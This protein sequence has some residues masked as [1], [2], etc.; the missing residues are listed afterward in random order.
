MNQLLSS[1]K[2][3]LQETPTVQV[4]LVVRSPPLWLG[5][6]QTVLA[7]LDVLREPGS[8]PRPCLTRLT[9]LQLV[10]TKSPKLKFL[11]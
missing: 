1:K 8:A 3:G 9:L 10:L 11:H 6:C 7:V 4:M 2:V 5:L